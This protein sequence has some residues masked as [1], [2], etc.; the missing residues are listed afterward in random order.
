MSTRILGYVA[1]PTHEAAE[2]I[3]MSVFN[4]TDEQL[5]RLVVQERG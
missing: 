5:K 4:L 3:A 1:A 2:A